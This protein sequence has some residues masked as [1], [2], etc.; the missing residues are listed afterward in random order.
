MTPDLRFLIRKLTHKYFQV[1]EFS[2]DTS[3]KSGKICLRDEGRSRI[4]LE[5]ATHLV[6]PDA[7]R[8]GLKLLNL[9][10]AVFNISTV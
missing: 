4:L 7:K 10:Q 8:P 6:L 9:V 2:F 1:F 3:R 5:A